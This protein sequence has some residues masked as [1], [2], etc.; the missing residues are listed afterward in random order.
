MFN[1]THHEIHRKFNF[2]FFFPLEVANKL[3]VSV[4]ML[5][6]RSPNSAG[7]T[8]LG[9]TFSLEVSLVSAFSH[10]LYAITVF[11]YYLLS[12]PTFPSRIN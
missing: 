6:H 5:N 10:G 12:I 9:G 11:I 8:F 7:G 1:L 3:P 4:R 2:F